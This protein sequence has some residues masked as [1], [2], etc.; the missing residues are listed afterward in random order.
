MVLLESLRK[1]GS[2]GSN[3]TSS[4]KTLLPEDSRKTSSGNFPEEVVHPEEFRKTRSS[5]RTF[6]FPE[7]LSGRTPSSGMFPEEPLLP[8]VIFLFF[9]VFF[10]KIFLN[11]NCFFFLNELLSISF[12]VIMFCCRNEM[13]KFS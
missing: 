9:F 1:K 6:K 7:D 10:F 12:Y 13:L 11:R 5:G 4:G 2:S 8:E 3:Q